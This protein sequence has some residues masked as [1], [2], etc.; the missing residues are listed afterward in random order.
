MR[1]V[2]RRPISIGAAAV[3]VAAL[4]VAGCGGQSASRAE[5]VSPTAT[6]PA[7]ELAAA[8]GAQVIQRG[9]SVPWGVAFLPDGSALVSERDR[10]RILR[11]PKGG[12][13][14]PRVVMTVP[15]VDKNSGEG[16]LLGLAVSPTYAKDRLVYAY[17]TAAGDNRVVRFRLG[18]RPQPIVTGIAK[19]VFHN[20]GRIAFGP[21][22]MLYIGTGDAGDKPSA[23]DP[24]S[25]NG[26]VL[27]VRPNGRAAPGNPTP[28]SRV[29]SLGHRN[30]QGLAF[31]AA[32]RL[33]EDEFGENARDEV[34]LIQ[35]GRN[36]GWPMVEGTGDTRGGRLT[37]P[38]VTWPTAEASPSGAAIVGNAMYVAALRGERV[39][40]VPL[41]GA[42]AGTP[43]PL[44]L[45]RFGRLRTA[46]AAPDGS[47]W[48]TTSNRDG[49][50]S[51]AAADDRIVRLR[52]AGG[53]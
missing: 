52:P 27:R 12:T 42:R 16:G 10:A 48:V 38:Q 23:Q 35:K 45:G 36:Y 6:P 1:I 47:L 8:N 14:R 11:I 2:D 21:D 41:R 22:R 46:V 30:V 37:N 15:G 25:L 7:A 32:G 53:R 51:P 19:N 39:W 3:A 28:G 9:L 26:K 17:Y 24:R 33:W 4:G 29:W 40:R 44:L 5:P 49:R 20:G 13:G 43:E 18:G 50:G 31:D 34:N